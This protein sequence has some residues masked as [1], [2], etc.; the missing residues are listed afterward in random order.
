M[1]RL[2]RTAEADEDRAQTTYIS[3]ENGQIATSAAPCGSM[4]PLPIGNH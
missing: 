2:Q 1:V 4:L 3:V